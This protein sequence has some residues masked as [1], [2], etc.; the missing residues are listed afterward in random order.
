MAPLDRRVLV[1]A[2]E[3]Q[4]KA[5]QASSASSAFLFILQFLHLCAVLCA[6][7]KTVRWSV[8]PKFRV[9][10]VGCLEDDPRGRPAW[11]TGEPATAHHEGHSVYLDAVPGLGDRADF[12]MLTVLASWRGF[13]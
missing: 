13:H 2:Q 8:G 12:A 10:P 7:R 1:R 11:A 3:G 4:L 9:G 6:V 5:E